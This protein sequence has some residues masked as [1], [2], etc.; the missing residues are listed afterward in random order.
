MGMLE[1]L[2]QRYTVALEELIRDEETAQK[3]HEDLLK[4]NA[5]FIAET[6][7]TKNAKISER[8]TLINQISEE[9]ATM[10]VNLVELHQVSKYLQDL[11]PS[12]DDIRSTFEERKKRREA[13]IAALK[14]A[15]EV[16]SD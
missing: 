6:T 2:L 12:C 3:L 11:R 14:E 8:R 16:I 1:D 15:L 9:K 13:E 10:K 5:Q 7:A 4:R